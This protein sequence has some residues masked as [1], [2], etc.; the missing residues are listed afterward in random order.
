MYVGHSSLLF[1]LGVPAKVGDVISA[2]V[3][4]ER[5]VESINSLILFSKSSIR[6]PM[7]SILLFIVL[8]RFANF[9]CYIHFHIPFKSVKMMHFK[10]IGNAPIS[11]IYILVK[12]NK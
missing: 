5:P 3:S 1:L 4:S 9:F 6:V 7:S 8:P 12:G 2:E 10:L 11:A